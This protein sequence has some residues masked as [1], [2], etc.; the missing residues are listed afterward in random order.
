MTP[1]ARTAG[2]RHEVMAVSVRSLFH[3]DAFRAG[4][5]PAT[6]NQAGLVAIR[7]G[8]GVSADP[9]AKQRVRCVGT[10]RVRDVWNRLQGRL[11]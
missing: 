3:K 8:V 7:H 2:P 4:S 11:V 1:H 9:E 6:N 10:A 5:G